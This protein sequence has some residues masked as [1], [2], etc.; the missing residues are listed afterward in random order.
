M[1]ALDPYLAFN[2][3]CREAME[4]YQKAFGGELKI[5]INQAMKKTL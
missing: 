2:G 5:V 3:N 1:K 4:F